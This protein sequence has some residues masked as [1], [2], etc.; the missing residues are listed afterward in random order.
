MLKR[1]RATVIFLPLVA[2]VVAT[3]ALAR[4]KPTDRLSTEDKANIS[5]IAQ[6]V[7]KASRAER[8]PV[9]WS[10]HDGKTGAVVSLPG[11]PVASMAEVQTMLAPD[12]WEPTWTK[13]GWLLLS[14]RYE[15]EYFILG[16][17]FHVAPR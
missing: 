15:I 11:Q 3:V 4:S 7:C 9:D 14:D 2:A 17:V 5:S 6:R 12:K 10:T 1:V 13:S 16:T 8:C